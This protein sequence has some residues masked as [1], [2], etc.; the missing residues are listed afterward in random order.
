MFISGCAFVGI[1]SPARSFTM[2][3]LKALTGPFLLAIGL[4]G[5]VAFFGLPLWAGLRSLRWHETP[6]VV[7]SGHLRRVYHY[8]FMASFA[9]YWPDVIYRYEVGGVTYRANT[10]NASDPGSPW[11]YGARGIVRRHP[12]G[13]KTTC[14]VNP[15]DPTE[16]VMTRSLSGTQ[17]FGVWPLTMAVLGSFTIVESATRRVIR[18]GS[19]QLWGTLILG[20]VTTSALTFSWISAADLIADRH[21]GAAEWQEYAVTAFAAAMGIGWSIVW[22]AWARKPD[23]ATRRKPLVDKL[24][25][26]WDP[27]I[28][29]PIRTGSHAKQF[30]SSTSSDRHP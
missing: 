4:G 10:Y 1:L 9:V 5:Y 27:E 2:R 7:E 11:Y 13:M 22:I 28:D 30:N 19:H 29:E 20:A 15:T 18:F 25:I 16:A 12:V 8:S 14:Y 26:V 17:W 21:A 3:I 6:C 23:G 24:P